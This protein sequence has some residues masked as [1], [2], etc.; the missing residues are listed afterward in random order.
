MVTNVLHDP[1]PEWTTLMRAQIECWETEEQQMQVEEIESLTWEA[2][3]RASREAEEER[4]REHDVLLVA[5]W[6][7][8]VDFEEAEQMR[9]WREEAEQAERLAREEAEAHASEERARAER[10][11]HEMERDS[12]P[13]QRGRRRLGTR[14]P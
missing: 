3:E 9:R 1:E 11:V 5:E 14:E 12:P 6:V 10:I 8:Q 2:A 13:S 4:Q 7:A